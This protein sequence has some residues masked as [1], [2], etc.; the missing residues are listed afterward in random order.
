MVHSDNE[1]AVDLVNDL[2]V[3]GGT[4]HMDC[5]IMFLRELKKEGVIR[6][7]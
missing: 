2:S 1:G 4:K 7:H 5:K 6:V 3:A